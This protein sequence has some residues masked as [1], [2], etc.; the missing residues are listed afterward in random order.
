[1]LEEE[2]GQNDELSEQGYSILRFILNVMRMHWEL[3][4]EDVT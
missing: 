1:M 4:S 2:Q 3:L